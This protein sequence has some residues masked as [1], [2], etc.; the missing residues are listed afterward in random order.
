MKIS[1]DENMNKYKLII[2]INST[3]S[4]SSCVLVLRLDVV[5]CDK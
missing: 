3:M 1:K 5:L 2:L 4:A